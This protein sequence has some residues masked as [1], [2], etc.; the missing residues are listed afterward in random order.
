[1]GA[2]WKAR[3]KEV[4]ANAKGKIFGK[5]AKEIMVAAKG[6]ADPS[7]EFAPAPG[8]RASQESLHAQRHAGSR[9][10]EGRRPARWRGAT[11]TPRVRRL[12]PAPRARHRR[13]P[14]RQRQ[15]HQVQHERAVPQRPTRRGRL[16]LVGLQL[17][18]HDRSDTE[19]QGCRPRSRRH[20][21][22]RAGLRAR[23]KKARPS[24]SP[25]SPTWMPCARPCPRMASP[26]SPPN[27]AIVPRIPSPSRNDAELEEVEA[28][29][30]AIDEDDD[31]QN[32]YVG[33]GIK[34]GAGIG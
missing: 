32:V 10:Q 31:V 14:V 28:F 7:L 6:G 9:H 8:G 34:Q 30:E 26:S 11:G 12:R 19:L 22:G 20:R 5:L 25:T 33:L 21:S 15:P 18:R 16:R 17:R 24:S 3:H 13:M 23:P 27:S 1:M 29:L 4:A 2:Q